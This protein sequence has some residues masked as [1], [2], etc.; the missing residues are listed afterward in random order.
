MSDNL[1]KT[2]L[3][4]LFIVL[5]SMNVK[6]QNQCGCTDKSYY[7]KF[8]NCD[9]TYLGDGIL[10]YQQFNCDSS[11][12]TIERK[13]DYINILNSFGQNLIEM[14][15][16]LGYKFVHEYSETLLF[17]NRQV[18]GGGVP[19]NYDVISK[20]T[21]EITKRLGA[22]V[23]YS[24]IDSIETIVR[25]QNGAIPKFEFYNI[26]SGEAKTYV[27]SNDENK[28]SKFMT[29]DMYPENHFREP[30]YENGVFTVTYRYKDENESKDWLSSKIVIDTK[31]N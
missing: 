17:L 18:S 31:L 9:T 8:I 26:K 23:Y 30:T 10:L 20:K 15:P 2:A 24:N 21:G 1:S 6:G 7:N 25:I 28:V 27:I 5:S 22:I 4:I 14:T 19:M 3:S 13:G 16:K 11:W 29:K 12:L